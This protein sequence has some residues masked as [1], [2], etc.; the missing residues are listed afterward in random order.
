MNLTVEE[1]FKSL[2]YTESKIKNE[3]SHKKFIKHVKVLRDDQKKDAGTGESLSNG[4]GFA[5]FY[6]EQISL[7]AIRYL[8]N[9]ELVDKKGLIVDYSLED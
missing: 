3:L 8:N 9:M 5:E 2:G 6:D 1:W 4:I 7:F